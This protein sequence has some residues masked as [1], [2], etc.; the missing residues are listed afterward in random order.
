MRRDRRD[1]VGALAQR[2]ARGVTRADAVQPGA[3][4]RLTI[5]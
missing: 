1:D 3:N 2:G 5:P 4:G